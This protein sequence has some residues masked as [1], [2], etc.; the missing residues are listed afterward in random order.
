MK[1]S[2]LMIRVKN[3]KKSFGNKTALNG[4]DFEIEKGE[5]FGFL[6]PNGA[7][8]TTTIKI[9]TG[10]LLPGYGEAFIKGMDVINEKERIVPIIG[11]VPEQ[12][13]LYER[14]SIKQNLQFYCSL[15][16]CSSSNIDDYLKLVNLQ[17]EKET[18]IKNL[19]K[20]M[21]QKVLLIRALL[22]DPEILFLDEPTSGLDPAS[23]DSIH[24]LLQKLNN[25]GK[26]I[27]LTSHNMEEVDKLCHRVAFLNEG[28]I[29][30]A[31]TPEELKMKYSEKQIK[32]T[33]DTKIG[34]IE[35]YI[36]ISGDKSAKQLADWIKKGKVKSIHSTEA[37]L[38]DIFV[39]ITGK[40]V[41]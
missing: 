20:G 12:S 26:T 21:R 31:G 27:F 13:N 40:E 35:R 6:G 5:I 16:Q 33:L 30:T 38:A 24:Y 22:H 39:K 4:I 14:L 1:R 7:G 10:K 25:Q 28:N 18:K 11:V 29:I 15:Y 23:G 41:V 34:L 9:L 8:K 19:S 32:I 37:S 3:L 17:K 2:D 36:D